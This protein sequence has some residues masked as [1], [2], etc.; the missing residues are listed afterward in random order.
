[1]LPGFAIGYALS[2]LDL[3]P[4]FIPILGFLDDLLIL[5]L[6]LWLALKLI[7]QD[8]WE[9]ARERAELEPVRLADNWAAAAAVFLLW[10]AAS[11]A[12][13]WVLCRK[14]GGEFVQTHLWVPLVAVGGVLVAAEAAWVVAT[15]CREERREESAVADPLLPLP[16]DL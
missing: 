14:F 2:P 12:L 9:R 11:L 6:L 5:P 16:A 7:P 4:D 15:W 3:I 13:V 1:M 10:D 8:I